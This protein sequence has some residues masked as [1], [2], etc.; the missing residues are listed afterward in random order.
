MNTRSSRSHAVFT[1]ILRKTTQEPTGAESV[2]MSKLHLV[3]LA[4]S[5][6]NKKTGAKGLR[7]K[8]SVNINKGLLALGN[9]IT[10]LGDPSKKGSHVPYRQSRI[11]RLLQV[12][13]CSFNHQYMY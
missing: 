11:T 6:R 10:A 1:I 5:E 3:D 8:E 7:F 9:V 4:G 13:T 2:T 12:L